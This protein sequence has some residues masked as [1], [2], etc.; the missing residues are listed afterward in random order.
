MATGAEFTIEGTPFANRGYDA[1]A[2][3]VVD[4]QL[5]GAPAL[6]VR[7]LVY[8]VAFKSPGAPD[9]V[10]SNSGVASPPTAPVTVTMPGSGTHSYIIG[11]RANNGEAVLVNGKPDASVNTKYR[12]IAVRSPTAQLRK[13]VATETTEYSLTDGWAEALA[14]IVDAVEAGGGGTVDFDSVN[15]ALATA[16]APIDVNGQKITGL[17]APVDPDDAATRQFVLDNAAGGG[18]FDYLEI[19]T[20]DFASQGEIRGG[21]NLSIYGLN[22]GG[23]ADRV[24]LS[25]TGASLNIGGSQSGREVLLTAPSYVAR[26]TSTGFQ[27]GDGGFSTYASVSATQALFNVPIT[28]PALV[29]QGGTTPAS[30]G[31]VRAYNEQL[32]V[33][34][35]NI[36]DDGDLPLLSTSG[37]NANVGGPGVSNVNVYAA[38]E[39]VLNTDFTPRVSVTSVATT[40]DTP[41]TINGALTCNVSGNLR[42]Q[43]TGTGATCTGTLTATVGMD[44]PFIALGSTPRAA[45]GYLRVPGGNGFAAARNQANTEDYP[46]WE[47]DA[48]GIVFG[49][50]TGWDAGVSLAG[51]DVTLRTPANTF[52]LTDTGASLGTGSLNAAGLQRVSGGVIGIGDVAGGT[53]TVSRSGQSVVMGGALQ[54]GVAA[55]TIASSVAS[56]SITHTA[57]TTDAATSAL[58][59]TSQGPWASATGTNRNPGN[60]ILAVPA[61]AS[62]GSVGKV[63]LSSGTVTSDFDHDGFGTSQWT[64]SN[65]VLVV[66]VSG[67]SLSGARIG[68]GTL[69]VQY[70]G[71]STYVLSG[72]GAVTVTAHSA[73]TSVT[74]AHTKRAGAG[75]SAG[76]ITTI[77]SQDGQDQSGANAN[78]DGGAL[79]IKPG[80]AGTGGSGAAGKDGNIALLGDGSFGGG[81]KVLSIANATTVPTSNPSGGAILYV[82]SGA[83][84]VRGSSG[85]VTTIAPAD[86]HC[87]FCGSDF[88]D[89]KR[90]A[91]TGE[92]YAYCY[93][94]EKAFI[95]IRVTA[96]QRR[97]GYERARAESEENGRRERQAEAARLAAEQAARV[98]AEEAEAQ[99]FAAEEAARIATEE[100]EVARPVNVAR[101]ALEARLAAE[102][103]AARVAAAWR[104]G[105]ALGAQAVALVEAGATEGAVLLLDAADAF[106]AAGNDDAAELAIGLLRDAPGGAELVADATGAAAA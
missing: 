54:L 42:F 32:A 106:R 30:T 77:G 65:N 46:I 40:I 86:P 25:W 9:P 48:D 79:R 8:F 66:G 53:V 58:T 97:A 44:A 84:K 31:L 7:S 24:V 45:T 83:T 37:D 101:R 19:G 76:G 47:I 69:A 17:A 18:P 78:N 4:L 94:C 15:A 20:S 35:R 6:D 103:E 55:T 74:H 81:G 71:D 36:D 49:S 73:Q 27:V 39:V 2:G 11:A 43:T 23:D 34:A 67:S 93:L 91:Y 75:A 3:Q 52:G 95:D 68:I 14:E 26:V 41:A 59:V 5:A 28:A 99:R 105:V 80:V 90:N 85:T 72:T 104:Q 12:M 1:T 60:L 56:P 102:Q 92:H 88:V 89:E 10:F 61:P 16:D 50:A 13:V 62:G 64:S 51:P 57:R 98:A 22:T 100:A 87:T 29:A 82:E 38:D 33:V 63:R 96:E 21:T 70:V